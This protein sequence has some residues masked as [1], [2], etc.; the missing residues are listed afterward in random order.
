MAADVCA[1]YSGYLKPILQISAL[2]TNISNFKKKH[3]KKG[4]RGDK[5]PVIYISKEYE[6]V[7]LK[8]SNL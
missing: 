6:I 8:K 1:D 4:K 3:R 5:N 7:L 2:D